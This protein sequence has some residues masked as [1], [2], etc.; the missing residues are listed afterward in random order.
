MKKIGLN[1]LTLCLYCFPFVYF[2]IYTDFTNGSIIGYLIM[3]IITSIIAFEVKCF[4]NVFVLIIGNILSAIISYFFICNII[5]EQWNTYFK[6]LMP[7]QLLI[8]VSL[9][10]LIPQLF[11]IKLAGKY[12]ERKNIK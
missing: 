2:S 3:I 7:Y 4:N 12:K 8:L 11:A 1:F 6:P 10:N 5:N 9:L